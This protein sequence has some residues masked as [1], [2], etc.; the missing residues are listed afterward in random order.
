MIENIRIPVGRWIA[1]G[2]DWIEVNLAVVFEGMRA[3]FKEMYDSLD[4]LFSTPPTLAIIAVF[5]ILGLLARGWKFAI[6]VAVGLMFIVTVGQWDNAADTLA[7]VV[8]AAF[9]AIVLS[10]PL[11]IWAAR[12]DTVSNILRPAMDFLQTMP[13][14]VYLMP[15]L[16]LLR[17]GVAPGILATILFAM[18][19]GVRLTELGIRGVNKEVVE[20]GEAFGATPRRILRQIQIP[21]AMPSIMAGINQIIMLALS[22]VVIAGLVGAGGLGGDVVR[23]LSSLD[24]ALGFEAGL[25]VVVI[26]IVLDRFTGSFGKQMGWYAVWRKKRNDAKSE[27]EL[28]E[29]EAADEAADD[30]A[31]ETQKTA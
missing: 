30:H 3:T 12:N 1:D 8:V 10:I 29:L 15:A 2:L 18:A 7:L 21:L 25:S 24:Y 16:A 5:A 27:A 9:F 22:M 13:A 31:A 11:G 14:F 28:A 4:W 19:P 17:V 26:A 23:S 6:G 20:A